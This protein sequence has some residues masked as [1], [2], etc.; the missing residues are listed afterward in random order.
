MQA[1]MDSKPRQRDSKGRWLK[2]VS[3]NAKGRPLGAKDTYWRTRNCGSQPWATANL[4][5]YATPGPR[6]D[7]TKGMTQLERTLEA[8][9]LLAEMRDRDLPLEKLTRLFGRV[10]RLL[11]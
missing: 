7:S 8:G 4:G 2:G 10:T 3:G 11:R 9:K 6:P 1:E 5:E